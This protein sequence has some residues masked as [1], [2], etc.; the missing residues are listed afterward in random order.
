ML[1]NKK[2]KQ[3]LFLLYHAGDMFIWQENDLAETLSYISSINNNNKPRYCK[4][5]MDV[6]STKR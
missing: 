3:Q 1:K 4:K 6:K 5:L 2:F